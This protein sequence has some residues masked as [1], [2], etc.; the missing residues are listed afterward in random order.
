[1]VQLSGADEVVLRQAL[2]GMGH[3]AHLAGLVTHLHVRV[4]VLP[5]GNP[6]RGVDERHGL[7]VIL[8]REGLFDS[9]VHQRPSAQ[10]REIAVDFGQVEGLGA[11]LTRLAFFRYQ[12]FRVTNG[13]LLG[14]GWK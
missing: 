11:P 12:V 14:I 2:D 7:V 9:S 3:V 4:M 5:V 13:S 6:G 10:H 8:E 1:M